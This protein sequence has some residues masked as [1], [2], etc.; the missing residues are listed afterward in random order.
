MFKVVIIVNKKILKVKYLGQRPVSFSELCFETK[1][2]LPVGML[3]SI[4]AAD[5]CGDWITIENDVDLQ[6]IY[7][8][9]KLTEQKIIKVN[10]EFEVKP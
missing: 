5:P 2:F 6:N 4:L 9:A 8:L 7:E 1:A 3:T 10:A